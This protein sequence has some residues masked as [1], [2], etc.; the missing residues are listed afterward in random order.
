MKGIVGTLAQAEAAKAFG[1]LIRALRARAS[2]KQT[3]VAEA[4]AVSAITVSRW[5]TGVQVGG[6]IW[7]ET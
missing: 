6:R 2:L 4:L 7:F 5:E 1:A 3:E